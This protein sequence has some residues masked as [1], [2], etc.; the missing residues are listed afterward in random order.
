[1]FPAVAHPESAGN[2]SPAGK[3]SAL[4]RKGEYSGFGSC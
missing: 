1:V 2:S 4:L 3:L